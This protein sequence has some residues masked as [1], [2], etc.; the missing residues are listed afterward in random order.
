MKKQVNS[1]MYLH[2]NVLR[3]LWSFEF[4]N[5]IQSAGF[6]DSK[7]LNLS[8]MEFTKP[9]QP[10]KVIVFCITYWQLYKIDLSCSSTPEN[11]A[12]AGLDENFCRNPTGRAAPWCYTTNPNITWE[13]CPIKSCPGI[14]FMP[15]FKKNS[16]SILS[17]SI[18]HHVKSLCSK[19]SFCLY[20]AFYI[21][22]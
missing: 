5:N 1:N 21:W 13:Y 2:S 12:F 17:L 22:N 3:V 19:F 6:W 7:W 20:I 16:W 15:L 4:W 10:W 11:H 9:P 14:S 8:G 18:P